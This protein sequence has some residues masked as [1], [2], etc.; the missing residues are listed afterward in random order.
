[1]HRI[2]VTTF[3]ILGVI[4]LVFAAQAQQS[5]EPPAS[6]GTDDAYR[7]RERPGAIR[8]SQANGRARTWQAC[9][10]SAPS[11]S[12]RATCSPTPS[13]PSVRRRP[14]ASVGTGQRRLRFREPERPVRPG[15][16]WAVAAA[17]L[18][19][20]RRDAATGLVDRRSAE[21]PP[22]RAHRRRAEARGGPAC[23]RARRCRRRTRTSRCTSGASRAVSSA[24][25]C[26]AATTT[27]MRSSRRRAT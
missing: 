22:A 9:R 13:S 6:G 4:A 16:R 8:I 19:R 3:G 27:G 1:M 15:R 24:P 12:A 18:V 2:R 25:S 5:G 26:R 14:L 11:R 17:T 23:Q 21:R 20:A 7:R 10:C